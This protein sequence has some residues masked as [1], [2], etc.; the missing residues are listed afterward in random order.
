MF[1]IQNPD[2]QR[3]CRCSGVYNFPNAEIMKVSY[4]GFPFSSNFFL[5]NCP[6]K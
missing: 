1:I 6:V 2:A 4:A 5:A 3:A